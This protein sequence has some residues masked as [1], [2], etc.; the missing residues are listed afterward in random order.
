MAAH[1]KHHLR[2]GDR[3]G[4]LLVLKLVWDSEKKI[5]RCVCRCDCGTEKLF[6]VS[7]IC[8]GATKSCG[9]YGR[10]RTAARDTVHAMFGTPTYRAWTN[11]RRRCRDISNV[12]WANYGGRGITVCPEWE[13]S[14]RAF[15]EDMGDRPDGTT[16]DR[17]DVNKGYCKENCRWASREVQARNRT[18]NHFIECNGERLTISEWARRLGCDG[19]TISM[20]L[21]IGWSAE[22]AVTTPIRRRPRHED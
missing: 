4:R 19:S 9:C 8:R 3:R 7:N 5:R 20:R 1:R 13:R 12:S 18:D 11:M 10:E 2:P 16:L 17:I 21:K 15:F 6:Q 22:R 14:F